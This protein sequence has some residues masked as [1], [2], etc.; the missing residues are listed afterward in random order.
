MLMGPQ[1]CRALDRKPATIRYRAALRAI[2]EGMDVPVI[3]R[4]D[5]MRPLAGRWRC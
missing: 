4:Y 5:L 1:H 2:G 3:R